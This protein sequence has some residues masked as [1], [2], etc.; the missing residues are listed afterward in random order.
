MDKENIK[1]GGMEFVRIPKGEF[2]MGSRED[3]ELAFGDEFPQHTL[4]V[5]YDYWVLRLK[6]QQNHSMPKSD[7]SS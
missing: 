4:D 5:P 6:F 7:P 1:I 3:N 2:I